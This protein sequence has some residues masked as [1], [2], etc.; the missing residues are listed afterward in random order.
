MLENT[1]LLFVDWEEPQLFDELPDGHGYAHGPE[2]ALMSALLF[3]AIQLILSGRQFRRASDALAYR[4]T[5]DWVM[6]RD[7][8]YVFSFEN[9]CEGLGIN[10][11]YLRLGI[12]NICNSKRSKK[13]R[14]RGD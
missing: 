12:V 11:D 14:R 5:C 7:R 6:S 4:E 1:E 13:I 3:D 10:P 8:D 2:R 9:V